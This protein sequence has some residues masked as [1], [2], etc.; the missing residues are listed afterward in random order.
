VRKQLQQQ[1]LHSQK[2]EAIGRLTGGIAHEFNNMLTALEGY[3]E[4]LANNLGQKDP[5][6]EFVQKI[7]KVVARSTIL[8]RQ[9][10]AFSHKQELNFE[11]IN[12]NKLVEEMEKL[13]RKVIGVDITLITDLDPTL[14]YISAD[15]GQIEQ[16]I[17]NLAVNSVDAMPN[18]GVLSIITEMSSVTESKIQSLG[19]NRPGKF[20]RIMISDTGIGM[21]ET[22]KA[23]IFDP[24]FSTKEK[25]KGTGL[26]LSTVYG[27]VKQHNGWITVDSSPGTGTSFFICFPVVEKKPTA[28]ATASK[29][30][31]NLQG[32]GERILLVEDEPEVREFLT[33]ALRQ[34][35]YELLEANDANQAF[36][37]LEMEKGNVD[38]V[39][40]DVVLPDLNGIDLVQQI[41]AENPGIK[42]VLNSGYMD[43]KIQI[44]EIRKKGFLF[45][46]KP[47]RLAELLSTVKKALK[48]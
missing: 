18:G 46:Q 8:S 45:L 11:I 42:V 25:E 16:V 13:L 23:Q 28:K 21:D 27:I 22:T 2:M 47:Y 34:S 14:E 35:G 24:F 31:A 6:Q 12:L 26:G 33:R 4:L 3:S 5:N 43:E 39:F 20:A 7:R 40:S 9:L 36:S 29:P 32:S 15:P 38:L 37:I 30:L 44:S 10:L 17:M 1:L 19:E 48:S 41:V